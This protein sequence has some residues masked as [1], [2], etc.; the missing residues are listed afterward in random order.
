[1][2]VVIADDDP[3]LQCSVAMLLEDAGH[4]VTVTC[5]GVA[6]LEAILRLR[7]DVAVLDLD[8]PGLT[9]LEVA[10]RARAA[11]GPMLRLVTLTGRT[12]ADT[13]ALCAK[14]GFDQV[15]IKPIT[16]QMLLDALNPVARPATPLG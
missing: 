9:G 15:C 10:Q 3:A 12:E 7:P 11:L 13:A 6:A 1:M 2:R 5:D 14:A 4:D 8:M 16:P